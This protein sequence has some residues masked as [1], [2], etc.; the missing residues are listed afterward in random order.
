MAEDPQP[1]LQRSVDAKTVLLG[2]AAL[3]SALVGVWNP[4]LPVNGDRQN[5][6]QWEVLG[7]HSEKLAILQERDAARTERL[8]A[9]ESELYRLREEVRDLK[10]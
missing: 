4:V 9:V 10:R 8:A 6:R 5:E 1:L 7:Q 3:G 2:L